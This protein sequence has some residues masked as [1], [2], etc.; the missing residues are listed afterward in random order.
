MS[1]AWKIVTGPGGV[2]SESDVPAQLFWRL[3]QHERRLIEAS[4]RMLELLKECAPWLK[5]N[6]LPNGTKDKLSQKIR[7]IITEIEGK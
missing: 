5:A 7:M 4:P 3:T 2:A 1:E 6:G